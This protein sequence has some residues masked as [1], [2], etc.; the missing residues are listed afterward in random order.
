VNDI[1]KNFKENIAILKKTLTTASF[2]PNVTT[3]RFDSEL[4]LTFVNSLTSLSTQFL[5][6]LIALAKVQNI[7]LIQS[8]ARNI[9]YK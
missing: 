1:F 3:S 4:T 6:S 8:Q 7:D 9:A 5:D 2:N